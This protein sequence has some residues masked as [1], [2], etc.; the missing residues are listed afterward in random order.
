MLQHHRSRTQR[1]FTL[2]EILVTTAIFAIIMIAALTV[3][4]RSNRIFKS[5]SEAADLQQSTRIGFDKLV[6][7]VRMAGFDYN[8]GGTPSGQNVYA[9]WNHD[10]IYGAGDHVDPGNGY[11]YTCTESGTSGSSAPL[12]N[13]TEGGSTNDGSVKWKTDTPS[14][15]FAQP[16]EQIEYAG[17]NVLA[18]RANFDYYTDTANGNGL[19]PT[20]TPKNAST[21]Q[22]IFP[23]V[24]TANSEI[25]IYA[26]KSANTA[27]NNQS[28]SFWADIDKPRSAYPT[29]GK[30]K[31]VTLSGIDTTNDHP[32][33]T[34]YRFT[35]CDNTTAPCT[36]IGSPDPGTP[37][38]ENIR[39]LQ[40]YYYSDPTGKTILANETTSPSTA[41]TLTHNGDGTTLSAYDKDGNPT[42]A[43]GGDG[44]WDSTKVGSTTNWDDRGWR[45]YITSVRVKLVG[46]NSSPEPGYTNATET[47]STLKN[48]RQYTLQSL[49]V[50]RNLGL[51]GFPEPNYNPPGPPTITGVCIGHCAVPVV[52]WSAPTGGGPVVEYRIEWDTSP[53]GTF[54]NSVLITDPSLTSSIVTDD[55]LDPSVQRYFRMKALNDNGSSPASDLYAA[56]PKNNTKPAWPADENTVAAATNN[57]ANQITLTWKAPD[58]NTNPTLTCSGSGGSTNGTS[59]PSQEAIRYA[60]YRSTSSNFDP[61][62]TGVKVLDFYATS[63][64]AVAGP[65]ATV[66]WIDKGSTSAAAPSACVTY[67]YRIQAADRCEKSDSYNTSNDAKSARS[68]YY[69][70]VGQAALSGAATSG[71]TPS[72]PVGLAADTS[73]SSCPAASSTNCSIT[74]KWPKVQSDTSGN[75]VGIDTYRVTRLRKKIFDVSFVADTSFTPTD[76]SGFTSSSSGT[77]SYTDT[78]AP[79]M[80]SSDGQQWYYRYTIAAKL[81]TTY[82]AESNTAD[83]PTTCS[84]NPTIVEVGATNPASTGTSPAS[85]WIMNAGDTI[86]VQP[87]AG[88][89]L[90]KV[91][92]DV[93]AYPAGTSVDS[94]IVTGTWTNVSNPLPTYTWSDRTDNQVYQILI[95]VTTSTGC[96]ETHIRY[97]KDQ[98]A[99]AC[100]YSVQSSPTPGSRTT[101]GADAFQTQNLSI[102]VS[103]SDALIFAGASVNNGPHS[104]KVTFKDPDGQHSDLAL[105]SIAYTVT[106]GASTLFTSTDTFATAATVGTTTRTIVS[107]MPNIS[108]GQTLSISLRYSYKKTE[109]DLTSGVLTGICLDYEIASEKTAAG[110]NTTKFCNVVGTFANNPT[111]CN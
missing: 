95:R 2:A 13:T 96:I 20:F 76:V 17:Q 68:D 61:A 54:P 90:T 88:V 107:A 108:P 94:Q 58:T 43:I 49:I 22:P 41:F 72:T 15:Q 29:N 109:P 24:S 79:Y 40:F 31:L 55:G 33:Y 110:K 60:V 100:A 78:T 14:A 97:V 89:T 99:A 38:A 28:I 5:S 59:I 48:Y 85:A 91:Q 52:Y 37:V 77:A 16:D 81:C 104:I 34:L 57:Q 25:V 50:P 1:G 11:T 103:G 44:Q 42:G 66:T 10:S 36:N 21:N 69:P 105:L 75:S 27:Y 19:E 62:S 98:Q 101:S 71:N 63:Q 73:T 102:T 39:S 64:P 82:S 3:Y 6:A 51:T 87:P 111:S 9:P 80:D 53:S 65:G 18:F 84:V 30:E 4:D 7:D 83:Y 46:I 12:W 23:Y 93:T 92:F 74:L 8:R 47:I 70:P 32:P 106:S 35:L 26:L 86:S 67:Y 45:A 56:T